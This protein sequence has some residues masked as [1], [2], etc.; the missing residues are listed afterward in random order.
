[1]AGATFD[2]PAKTVGNAHKAPAPLLMHVCLAED[3]QDMWRMC[4]SKQQARRTTAATPAPAACHRQ[5]S[6]GSPPGAGILGPG[7]FGP[8]AGGG[9]SESGAEPFTPLPQQGAD[10]TSS[11]D[12][13]LVPLLG[14]SMS[15]RPH[16]T[17][18][19]GLRRL[20][21]QQH[22]HSGKELIGDLGIGEAGRVAGL[23]FFSAKHARQLH[24]LL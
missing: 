15:G 17:L 18:A 7:D 9:E 12:V 20:A 3:D 11:A 24:A 22:Q 14:T 1:M 23:L 16:S 13:D 21:V 19:K 4:L 10:R 8:G 2:G 6:I 5:A